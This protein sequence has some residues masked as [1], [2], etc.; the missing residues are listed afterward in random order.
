[1]W[2]GRVSRAC[3]N[4]FTAVEFKMNLFLPFIPML[5]PPGIIPHH[6]NHNPQVII[7]VIVIVAAAII[8][9]IIVL[10]LLTGTKK[11]CKN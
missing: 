3:C 2:I 4:T 11:N 7:A 8:I 1:M 5:S 6:H 9:I 10:E